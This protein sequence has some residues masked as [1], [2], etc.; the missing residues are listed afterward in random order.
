MEEPKPSKG[1]KTKKRTV[2]TPAHM[3][4]C[5]MIIRLIFN[6]SHL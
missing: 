6:L 1:M 3:S 2:V 4:F 5:V